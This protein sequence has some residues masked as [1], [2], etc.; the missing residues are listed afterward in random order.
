VLSTRHADYAEMVTGLMQVGASADW[1]ELTAGVDGLLDHPAPSLLVEVI[2]VTGEA[3]APKQFVSATS[4]VL[5]GRNISKAVAW[6]CEV[7]EH[8]TKITGHSG[9][10][11][12]SAAGA[13]FQVGWLASYDTPQELDA[14]NAAVSGD[15][16]YNEM[17]DQAGNERWFVDG[18]IDRLQLVKMA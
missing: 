2:A 4:A 6:S 3:T 15:A 10:V 1:A 11:G 14:V 12:M 13:M 8:V 18:S 16:G 5:T 9:M 7:A 17:I